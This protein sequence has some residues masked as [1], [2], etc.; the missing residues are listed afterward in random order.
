[1]VEFHAIWEHLVLL[2][3]IWR[4]I[5]NPGRLCDMSAKFTIV[6]IGTLSMNR[7]WNENERVRSP[8]A[9]CTLLQ[10]GVMRLL[11]DPSPAP[12]QLKSKLFATTGLAPDDINMVFLTHFHA[13]H[14]FGLPLFEGK[15][16]LMAERGM[17]EWRT[18]SSSDSDLIDRF[19]PAEA[20]LPEGIELVATP[21]HTHGH[22][23]LNVTSDWGN[24]VVAGDAA[25]TR[26]FLKA[27]EGFHNSV[28]FGQ[29]SKTIRR[30]KTIADLIIPGHDSLLV[31]KRG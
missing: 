21:G 26:D 12:E 22:H 1:M 25:M 8:S 16:F 6:N 14:R 28:D 7:F 11:V 23:S 15:G 2:S 13:D 17:D 31:C 4:P 27:E 9:T 18:L 5:K 30:L 3:C 10:V 19:K 29:A 20:H 24:V